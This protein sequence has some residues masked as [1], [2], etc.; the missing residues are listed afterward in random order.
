M[1]WEKCSLPL[2]EKITQYGL[3][4]KGQT[5]QPDSLPVSERARQW[6]EK[7]QWQNM[8]AADRWGR[9]GDGQHRKIRRRQYSTD[10]DDKQTTPPTQ[11]RV[12]TTTCV[13]AAAAAAT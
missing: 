3:G 4:V 1:I 10:D 13:L 2:D 9:R 7:L 12:K 11:K 8:N 6:K 5:G